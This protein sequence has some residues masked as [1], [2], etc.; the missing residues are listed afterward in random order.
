[1]TLTQFKLSKQGGLTRRCTFPDRPYWSALASKIEA[2]YDIPIDK[3]GVTYVDSD[4]DQVTLSSEEELAEFYQVSHHPP[5][6]I[7]FT[8]QDLRS[9]RDSH[10]PS[11]KALPET[12]RTS[13]NLRNTF[14]G[15]LDIE[16]DW[17]L[18]GLSGLFRSSDIIRPDSPHAYLE[19]IESDVARTDKRSSIASDLVDLVGENLNNN[20][21]Q[22]TAKVYEPSVSDTISS[23]GSVLA[24]DAPPKHPLHVYDLSS[25]EDNPIETRS[26]NKTPVVQEPNPSPA[27]SSTP[28]VKAP[29]TTTQP[30]I[31]TEI[32]AAADDAPDPP[33]PEILAQPTTSSASLSHDI[34]TLLDTFTNV[35]SAHPELPGAFH[36]I[37]RNTASGTYW[38]SHRDA[39]SRGAEEIVRTAQEET[40]KAAEDF[41]R[42]AEEEAGRRVTEALGGIFRIFSDV[43]GNAAEPADNVAPAATTSEPLPPTAPTENVPQTSNPPVPPPPMP[44]YN[45]TWY[46]PT[47]RPNPFHLPPPP[48]PLLPQ[49]IFD[50]FGPPYPHTGPWG[51]PPPHPPRAPPP[52]GPG[53]QPEPPLPPKDDEAKATPEE[54]KAEVDLAKMKYKAEKERYRAHRGERRKEKQRKHYS[55]GGDRYLY[56]RV[57]WI[58]H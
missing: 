46:R 22:Q 10:N 44:P 52:A 43:T 39:L 55:T 36:N 9:L 31:A 15:A 29:D 3:V 30:V 8:V 7:K 28:T 24:E 16:D 27:A 34:A 51:M 40:G 6:P 49:H 58:V 18:P 54:I 12:P 1:M 25:H 2:L 53:P 11:S 37:F 57:Y 56:V 26:P 14:G 19:V 13:G 33:L 41:R 48:P 5:Q 32:E 23:T 47:Y 20:N 50:V 17:Q 21:N 4:G 45:S 42:I 38:Q 35:L